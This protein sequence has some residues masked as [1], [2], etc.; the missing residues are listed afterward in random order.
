MHRLRQLWPWLF[1][2]KSWSAL[3]IFFRVPVF[4]Y[5]N[6]FAWWKFKLVWISICSFWFWSLPENAV[7]IDWS[8]KIWLLRIC[9]FFS[10]YTWILCFKLSFSWTFC[11]VFMYFLRIF[12]KFDW[13]T[14]RSI[15]IGSLDS[16]FPRFSEL[17]GFCPLPWTL[18]PPAA[19]MYELSGLFLAFLKLIWLWAND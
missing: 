18:T 12:T 14:S 7:L 6:S 16:F 13:F 10:L 1:T 11:L 15:I 4:D 17:L 19:R 3:F 8:C 5:E 9:S 2:L